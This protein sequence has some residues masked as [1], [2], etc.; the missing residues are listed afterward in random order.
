MLE[1]NDD[2]VVTVEETRLPGATDFVILPVIHSFIMDD[3]R[4]QEYTLRF[5]EKGYFVSEE[6]RHPI[7]VKTTTPDHLP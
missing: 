6:A 3:P 7:P 5:L 4:V 2:L 1:G